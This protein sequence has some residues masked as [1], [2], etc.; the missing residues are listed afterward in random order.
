MKRRE[1]VRSVRR[2]GVFALALAACTGLLGC[3]D[4]DVDE[5]PDTEFIFTTSI[6]AG[7]QHTLRVPLSLAENPP[8]GEVT[9]RTSTEAGHN[10]S[11]RLT[12]DDLNAI[13]DGFSVTKTTSVEDGHSHTLVMQ[14]P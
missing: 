1:F 10:H 12:A 8:S 13:D 14:R 2:A 3:A 7:H 4:D 11:V 5:T 6:E 9:L